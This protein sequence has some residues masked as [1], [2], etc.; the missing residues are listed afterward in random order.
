M[1]LRNGVFCDARARIMLIWAQQDTNKVVSVGMAGW[2][3][4]KTG[5][6][7]K[8]SKSWYHVCNTPEDG[9][10]RSSQRSSEI[11][12]K[13]LGMKVTSVLELSFLY[14]PHPHT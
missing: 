13:A 5:P 6:Q 12:A 2:K 7:L 9:F 14:F 1:L 10:L 3:L 4:W 8:Q 11:M